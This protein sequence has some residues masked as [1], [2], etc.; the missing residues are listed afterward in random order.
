MASSFAAAQNSTQKT[1]T[2]AAPVPPVAPVSPVS[3]ASAVRMP[4]MPSFSFEAN[5]NSFYK[6]GTQD[7]QKSISKTESKAAKENPEKQEEQQL[8]DSEIK[9]LFPQG[10]SAS[11]VA[12]LSNQG[13]F[14]DVSSI[15]G[16][17]LSG[18]DS[19]ENQV[20]TQV[21]KQLN[22]IKAAQKKSTSFDA[23]KSKPSNEPP[24]ILRFVVNNFD[25]LASCNSAY[26]SKPESDGS[27]L[28]TGDCK[29][30]YNNSTLAETF[31]FLFKA[32]G[33]ENGHTVYTIE[34]NLSQSFESPL[35]ALYKM[36]SEKKLTAVK[37][38]NLVTLRYKA[39]EISLDL[40]LD[41][42]K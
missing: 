39:N 5:Q 8:I 22:D 11:D 3:G 17:N 24:A 2:P 38:G 18:I 34:T 32:S 27:F 37:T 20:L 35:S 40:L 33:T 9:K 14:T 19:S 21:I 36:C 4:E 23:S 15:L 1:K 29:S 10:L 12:S 26:F 41:I 16:K 7:K 30:L 13:L 6:P 28:L 25:V 31:Y 42:G